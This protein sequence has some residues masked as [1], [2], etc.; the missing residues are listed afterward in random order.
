MPK[1]KENEEA[2]PAEEE[3]IEDGFIEH[4]ET[5]PEEEEEAPSEEAEEEEV[6]GDEDEPP[7]EEKEPE[8]EEEEPPARFRLEEEE[9]LE[10]Q[11][12][13]EG[14]EEKTEIIHQGR[15]YKLS[16]QE[17]VNLAQK[18]FDYD[19]KVAPHAKIVQMIEADP[20]LA[21]VVSN[22]WQGK[23]AATKDGTGE[24]AKPTF[25]V[26]PFSEYKDESEWLQDNL[27]NALKS[28]KPEVPEPA[29]TTASESPGQTA[30]KMLAMRDPKHCRQVLSKLPL[31]ISQLTVA[32]YQK[33]DSDRTGAALC[34]FY[35][36]VKEQELAKI[37]KAKPPV[38]DK[39]DNSNP[40]LDNPS[41]RIRSGGGDAPGE[42]DKTNHPWT[43]SKTDFQKQLDKV[44]GF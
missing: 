35:D 14:E 2:T 44:K 24:E 10:S 29:P 27:S 7:K 21:E 17:I 11:T 20:K 23:L 15:V 40:P 12:A 41:F 3:E 34:Q 33:I 31:Y 19:S 5:S 26:K 16:K 42:Q 30:A 13:T 1:P 4:P 9:P 32:D 25:T 18:G 36:F 22:Y 39:D 37:E 8:T 43:L 38:E 28:F 6:S